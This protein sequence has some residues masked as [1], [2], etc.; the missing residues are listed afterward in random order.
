MEGCG[1]WELGA[2]GRVVS[3]GSV[4]DTAYENVVGDLWEVVS[5][6]VEQ[7]A[8]PFVFQPLG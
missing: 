1:L 2:F 8:P 7:E 4:G 6:R 5:S 3:G